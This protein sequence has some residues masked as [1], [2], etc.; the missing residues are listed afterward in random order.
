M[1]SFLASQEQ[2][3]VGSRGRSLLWV[4]S[5]QRLWVWRWVWLWV[6]LCLWLLGVLVFKTAPGSQLGQVSFPWFS[7]LCE[8]PLTRVCLPEPPHS[9]GDCGQC[10]SSP[11][12]QPSLTPLLRGSLLPAPTHPCTGFRKFSWS[13]LAPGL[14]ATARNLRNK[15]AF[16][17]LSRPFPLPLLIPPFLCLLPFQF[18]SP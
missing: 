16:S 1:G 5:L 10:A 18:L 9:P 15:R 3:L 12:P 8:C 2:G 6:C 14:E 11:H 17:L 13:S 7:S 4:G